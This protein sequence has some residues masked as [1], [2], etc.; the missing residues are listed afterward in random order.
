FGG[1]RTRTARC[2]GLYDQARRISPKLKNETEAAF[3][4]Y[5]NKQGCERKWVCRQRGWQF[6]PLSLCR[7]R[8]L[9]RF[10]QTTWLD[11]KIK[12]WTDEN[13]ETDKAYPP[14]H[15]PSSP[16]VMQE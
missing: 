9:A 4:R 12:E 13:D 10:P 14:S 6:P 3:G 5:L 11:L 2:D 16:F 1:K 7:E 8:W 15:H